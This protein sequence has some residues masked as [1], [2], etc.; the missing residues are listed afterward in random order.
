MRSRRFLLPCLFL[1]LTACPRS[2]GTMERIGIGLGDAVFQV[3]VARTDRER[4]RGL[5]NRKALGEREGMLF[6]FE[7]D[8]HLSFW[9]KDTTVPLSIAFL[10]AS[11]RIEEIAD[12]EPLS[13]RIV[14]SRLSCRYALE[15]P[16]GAYARLGIGE[17]DIVKLPEG[18]R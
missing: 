10:S 5:M 7:S 17:G 9:M 3:E 11:G 8:Q 4:E 2:E 13:R 1:A 18:L 12:M 14:R 15:V 16:K 6:V